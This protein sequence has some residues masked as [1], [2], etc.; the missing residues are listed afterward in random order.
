MEGSRVCGFESQVRLSTVSMELVNT[1]IDWAMFVVIWLVQLVVYPGFRRIEKS[2]FVT[3]HSRYLKLMGYLVGP[4]MIGQLGF[5]VWNA[6][7]SRHWISAE[8]HY[9][10]L[11]ALTW[12]ATFRMVVPIH[13]KLQSRGNE[14]KLVRQLVWANWPRTVLW[15]AIVFV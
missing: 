15:S 11:V 4:L 7:T 9:L 10:G 2:R 8:T 14:S 1:V 3:W 12:I 6:F 5:A 13:D